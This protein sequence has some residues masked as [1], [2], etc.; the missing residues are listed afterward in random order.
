MRGVALLLLAIVPAFAQV[1]NVLVGEVPEGAH[2]VAIGSYINA[3]SPAIITA[4]VPGAVFN[5]LDSGVTWTPVS[6]PGVEKGQGLHMAADSKGT[7]YYFYAAPGEKGTEGYF[8]KS[9]DNGKE[10]SEAKS[11]GVAPGSATAFT[12]GSH[13]KKDAVLLLWTETARADGCTSNIIISATY[14]GGKKWGEPMRLNKES[15]TCDDS[16]GM[17]TAASPIIAKDGKVFAL[18]AANQKLTLDR[19]FDGG[20]MWI[21]SDLHVG[22]QAGGSQLPIPGSAKGTPSFA[23]TIDNTDTRTTGIIYVVFA[24]QRNG[25]TDTDIWLLRT[26]NHG[27]NWTYPFRINKDEPGAHQYSPRI[28]VDNASGYVY[29]TYFDRRID[30]ELA[31]DV[32]LA[33]STDGGGAFDEIKITQTPFTPEG[34]VPELLSVSA[35]KGVVHVLWT[36]RESGATKVRSATFRHD[37]LK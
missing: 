9:S 14:S 35:H 36:T 6:I 11:F 3:R 30:K 15:G 2:G 24:D 22:D 18:W 26:P 1:K 4:F 23:A 12:M 25:T 37:R 10:W 16:G 27:D 31:T 34:T 29:V 17:L 33:Y 20:K 19:S 8:T 7:L 28:A 5:S 21:S 32:Y 13:P